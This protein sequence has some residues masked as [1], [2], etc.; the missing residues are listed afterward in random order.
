MAKKC[1]LRIYDRKFEDHILVGERVVDGSKGLKLGLGVDTVLLV[2]KHL[3]QLRSISTVT[4]ALA[5][6]LSR[7]HNVL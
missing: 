6:N 2:Q 4:S 1:N 3:Q 5:H 7:E